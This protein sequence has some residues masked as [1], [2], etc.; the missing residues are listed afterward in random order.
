[1]NARKI[2]EDI[3]ERVHERSLV[4]SCSGEGCRVSMEDVPHNRV[5]VDL[6]HEFAV[7]QKR[8]KRCDRVLCFFDGTEK[9]LVA[10]PIELKS[11]SAAESDVIAQ[12]ESSL[13]FIK[14]EIIPASLWA[15][16]DYL[17]LMFRGG[18]IKKTSRKKKK[19]VLKISFSG[20]RLDIQ[21]GRCNRPRNL[22]EL[23]GIKR[24]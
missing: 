21:I 17:P 16:T 9:S 15:K 11:G 18:R 2:L 3:R 12:L 23:L 24:Q 7:R 10:A 8:E 22:A 19:Q 5:V 13:H 6:E 1:M 20:R 4:N 14:Q